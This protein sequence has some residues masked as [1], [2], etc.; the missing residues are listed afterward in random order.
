MSALTPKVPIADIAQ[1]GPSK[2]KDRLAA[3]SPKSVQVF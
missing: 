3:V 1:T 2:Q